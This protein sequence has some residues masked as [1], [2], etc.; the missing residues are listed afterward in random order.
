MGNW[1]AKP[2]IQ[3]T[4]IQ[5]HVSTNQSRT[6]AAR[7][8]H[9]YIQSV[10]N[11]W[12]VSLE[13]V[14]EF[15]KE[16]GMELQSDLT[17]TDMKAMEKRI[18]RSNHVWWTTSVSFSD[19]WF[20]NVYGQTCFPNSNCCQAW[21]VVDH[22][23]R[24][25]RPYRRLSWQRCGQQSHYQLCNQKW[26]TAKCSKPLF[27]ACSV[28]SVFVHGDFIVLRSSTDYKHHG[29][30]EVLTAPGIKPSSV[31]GLWKYSLRAIT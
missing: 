12:R 22:H 3:C 18:T 26:A 29:N 23:L 14:T 31:L 8:H 24:Q 2:Q 17:V 4:K 11:C 28:F 10:D 5:T 1:S 27:L 13:H 25:A 19:A 15:V 16:V 21:Q 30:L 9:W 6:H 20:S 7:E